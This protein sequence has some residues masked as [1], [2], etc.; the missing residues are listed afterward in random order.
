MALLTIS[1]DFQVGCTF[2]TALAATTD[3]P[4][5]CAPARGGFQTKA[6]SASYSQ[7]TIARGRLESETLFGQ[8]I[9]NWRAGTVTS[10]GRTIVHHRRMTEVLR[11]R[12]RERE[13]G[14]RDLLRGTDSVDGASRI[15]LLGKLDHGMAD[16]VLED[17]RKRDAS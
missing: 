13:R 3:A 15:H 7:T 6:W 12:E 11:S 14:W 10:L 1:F 9:R 4:E 8:G 17:L 2:H 16:E 5:P